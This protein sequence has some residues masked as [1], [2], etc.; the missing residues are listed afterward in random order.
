MQQNTT[1]DAVQ[2]ARNC[3]KINSVTQIG[4]PSGPAAISRYRNV[5]FSGSI[6]TALK[7]GASTVKEN[8]ICVR[9]FERLVS[10][11]W[12]SRRQRG[13]SAR[14]DGVEVRRHRW[15]LGFPPRS[16]LAA[17]CLERASLRKSERSTLVH[18]PTQ[19]R[20]PRPVA[21]AAI[22]TGRLQLFAISIFRNTSRIGAS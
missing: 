11:S 18:R 15:V 8:S 14:A 2:S 16:Q 1:K 9:L 5:Y 7:R 6:V 17:R 22:Y 12:R 20:T 3:N 13:R 4:S 21:P 10:S 19:N